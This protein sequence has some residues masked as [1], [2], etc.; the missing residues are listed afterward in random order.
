M[1]EVVAQISRS[2]RTLVAAL[3]DADLLSPSSLP[4]WDRLTVA[5]HLRYGA[6]AMQRMTVDALAGRPTA[7]YPDGREAQRPGTLAPR[8][9]EAPTDVVRSL[10]DE[11]SALDEVWAAIDDWSATV[12]E[13]EAN[14][15]L[16]SLELARL[17]L[18]RLTEVEVHGTDLGIGLGPWSDA[19]VR[20][21]LPM[22]LAWLNTRRSNHR[23]VDESVRMSWLLL[24]TD[25]PTR[26]LI[27]VDGLS[28]RSQPA[29]SAA[30]AGAVIRGTSRD[31][32]A[33]LLGRAPEDFAPASFSRALPGP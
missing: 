31:L 3:E 12:N 22:R 10:R 1:H 6:E 14:A 20:S 17:P 18:L 27:A 25:G 23:P 2:T 11:S 16:G 8:R 15:D 26:Q 9:G 30:K 7:Y 29:E 4:D 13:P 28:V 33:L 5:C 24:A 21:V 32:L 19:F